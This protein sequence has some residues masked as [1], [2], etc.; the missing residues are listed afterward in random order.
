MHELT[1]TSLKKYI[2]GEWELVLFEGEVDKGQQMMKDVFIKTHRLWSQEPC[3]ILFVDMDIL[4]CGPIDF[5]NQYKHFTMFAKIREDFYNCGLRYFPHTMDPALWDIGFE[6]YKDWNDDAEWDRDQLVYSKMLCS[7]NDFVFTQIPIN[8]WFETF[9]F[10]PE[11]LTQYKLL[12]FHSAK[13]PRP[14]FALIKKY[15]TG[16]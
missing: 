14:V 8:V 9:E 6:L 16:V 13:G 10:H 11:F 12:H 1:L 3:N 4:A 15:S 2:G 5:F 7:Q